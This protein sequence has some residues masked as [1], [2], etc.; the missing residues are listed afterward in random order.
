M[1]VPESRGPPSS[2]LLELGRGAYARRAW[3]D[4]WRWLSRAD[5]VAALVPEDL[6]RLAMAASLTGREQNYLQILDRTYHACLEGGEGL[7]AA[8]AAFWLGLRMTLR[9]ERGLAVGWLGRARR[10][11]HREGRPCVEEGY[12]LLP[13]A[14]EQLVRGEAEKAR[15]TAARAA[16]I[17][18]GFADLDLAT[19]ARH[20]EGR[21][22]I[23]TGKVEE[24]LELLDEAM[25]SVVEGALSPMI[26]GLVYCSVIESCQRIY[27]LERARSWTSELGKW[28]AAQPQLVAFTASCLVSRAEIMQV[29]GAWRE[30]LEEARRASA[31]GPKD[32]EWQAPGAAFYQQ[33][34]VHRLRG[35]FAQAE[36]AYRQAS[37]RGC[38]P[39]PGLALL[40]LAEGNSAVAAR[41]IE[42][43]LSAA[44]GLADRTK[45]LAAFVEIM[46]SA[47]ERDA[48]ERACGE[49]T[50]AAARFGTESLCAMA[51]QARGAVSLAKDNPDRA[52]PALR[53]A[54]QLWLKV[55]APFHA[56]RTRE[57]LALACRAFGDHEGAQ[58]ELT[59]AH[60]VYES[61]G[62]ERDL[63][64]LAAPSGGKGHPQRSRLTAREL[65]V[66]RMLA[67]GNSNRTIA[68]DLGLSKKTIDRHVSNIFD[69]LDVSSR[70]AAA[71]WAYEQK[72]V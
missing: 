11:V 47:G 36:K 55:E 72:L 52:L 40:R 49:L 5:E 44:T 54:L 24:G 4:A 8:R 34:E 38:E 12:L 19:C 46:L 22:L 29:G 39:Q 17:G 64:R 69:K 10:L 14:E 51:E 27:A 2:E 53:H 48:A 45:L 68:T 15:E 62:A 59:A 67:A 41:M 50:E 63:L 65:Q 25:L 71:A 60:E 13:L 43:A 57:L 20:V 16:K 66:L 28:C 26:A 35:H 56:A 18:E 1:S 33:G 61:L 23:E 31:T 6:E 42:R 3:E 32:R 58:L 7:P 37:R 9:G 21:A 70:T 30:A